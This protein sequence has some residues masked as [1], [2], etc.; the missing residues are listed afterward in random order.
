MSVITERR[1]VL[2]GAAAILALGCSGLSQLLH[3]RQLAGDWPAAAFDSESLSTA[4]EHLLEGTARPGSL[5]YLGV[6]PQAINGAVV[7]I[8]VT[9]SLP[10]VRSMA[11]L[12]PANRRP[13]VLQAI[14]GVKMRRSSDVVAVIESRSGIFSGRAKVE[15]A[16][17]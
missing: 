8:R 14:I 2:K 7:P 17:A 12:V 11:V 3:A 15:V 16:A 6:P 10:D 9:T 13:L 1:T 5:V 4:L